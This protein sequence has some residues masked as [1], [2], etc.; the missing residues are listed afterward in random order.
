MGNGPSA[1]SP[2]GDAAAGAG[3]EGE[4]RLSLQQYLL[5]ALPEHQA[6]SAKL[7]AADRKAKDPARGHSLDLWTVQQVCDFVEGC[8]QTRYGAAFPAVREVVANFH[9]HVIDG[10]AVGQLQPEDWRTLCPYIGPRLWLAKRLKEV[11]D[12]PNSP[13]PPPA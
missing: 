11:A 7:S 6:L 13:A 4:Y 10:L 2:G 8:C 12:G 9:G 3:L 5:T 1:A